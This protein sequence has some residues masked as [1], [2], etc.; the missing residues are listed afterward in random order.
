MAL[1]WLDLNLDGAT[2]PIEPLE[3]LKDLELDASNDDVFAIIGII[4]PFIDE[5]NAIL[6]K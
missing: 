4:T 1:H 2:N 6:A 3:Q 5:Y